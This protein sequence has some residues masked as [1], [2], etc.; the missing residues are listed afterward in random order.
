M[1]AILVTKIEHP[2][3]FAI[4]TAVNSLDGFVPIIALATLTH[5]FGTLGGWT[6]AEVMLLVG[7]CYV[8]VGVSLLLF[9]AFDS[10]PFA[11]IYRSGQFESSLLRPGNPVIFLAASNLRPYRV[12]RVIAGFVILTIGLIEVG[13]SRWTVLPMLP[14]MII[15][16]SAMLS[17]LW[18]VDA[19]ATVRLGQANDMTRNIPFVAS[20]MSYY[21]HGLYPPSAR[22]IAQF[23]F[24]I[25]AATYLPIAYALGKYPNLGIWS[26]VAGPAILPVMILVCRAIW[27]WSLRRF[28]A[29]GSK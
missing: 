17:S 28:E 15:V 13:A 27:R 12:G 8:C 2:L 20:E 11:P 22:F 16:G 25:G 5:R 3:A 7:S 29:E 6:F 1:R 4:N 10:F 18:F 24:G 19:A 9:G 26:L 14:L 23:V 21:P